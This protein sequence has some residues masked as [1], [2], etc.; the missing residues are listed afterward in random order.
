MTAISKEQTQQRNPTSEPNWAETEFQTLHLGDE[1]RNKRAKKLLHELG[2][3]PRASINTC[4]VEEIQLE[5]KDRLLP[6]LAFYEIIAW[7]VMYITYLGRASGE[8]PCDMIFAEEEWQSVYKVVTKKDPPQTVPRLDDFVLLLARLGGHNGRKLDDPPGPGAIW[9]G[10]RRCMDFAFA[11][12]TFG[13]KT[14]ETT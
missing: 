14:R 6:C 12:L 2:K 11:W 13:P 7:R 3:N 4:R 9:L 8:M 1:R 10:S 5:T